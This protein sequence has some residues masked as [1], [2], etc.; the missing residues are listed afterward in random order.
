M[1]H[2]AILSEERRDD[3][4]TLLSVSDTAFS[5]HM[6][7]RIFFVLNYIVI[8]ILYNRNTVFAG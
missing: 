4:P 7:S 2:Y 8:D 3:R 5:I 6:F 1:A